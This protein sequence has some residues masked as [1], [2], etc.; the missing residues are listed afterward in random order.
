MP[1]IL[2]YDLIRYL[3]TYIPPSIQYNGREYYFQL[4]INHAHYDIRVCYTSDPDK[5]PEDDC[6]PDFVFLIENIS[7]ELDL[8]DALRLIR[9]RLKENKLLTGPYMGKSGYNY[10]KYLKGYE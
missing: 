7:N 5:K 9:K 6:N 4:F 8:Y 10:K 1:H 2:K 3:S